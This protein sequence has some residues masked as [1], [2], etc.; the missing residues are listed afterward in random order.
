MLS[1]KFIRNVQRKSKSV[2]NTLNFLGRSTTLGTASCSYELSLQQVIKLLQD[3]NCATVIDSQVNI[4]TG[5]Q[6]EQ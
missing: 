2:I 6:I 3:S 1:I 4:C 5:S